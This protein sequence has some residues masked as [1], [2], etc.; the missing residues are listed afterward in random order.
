M[1]VNRPKQPTLS[2]G[3]CTG[4]GG[5]DPLIWPNAKS[6]LLDQN[7]IVAPAVCSVVAGGPRGGAGSRASRR[8]RRKPRGISRML[9]M[10]RGWGRALGR[11]SWQG[12]GGAAGQPCG[13]RGGPR[14]PKPKGP[15]PAGRTSRT[16][17]L[18]R[19]HRCGGGTLRV[20]AALLLA[21]DRSLAALLATCQRSRG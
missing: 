20:C 5:Q 2:C 3:A 12:G 14:P 9:S 21:C 1:C 13:R 15:P 8:S 19:P 18:Q 16:C 10:A 4:G 6:L 17:P 11:H 7:A